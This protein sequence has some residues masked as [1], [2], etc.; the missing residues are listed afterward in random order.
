[1]KIFKLFFAVAAF[2]VS[3]G[4]QATDTRYDFS[5]TTSNGIAS[6]GYFILGESWEPTTSYQSVDIGDFYGTLSVGSVPLISSGTFSDLKVRNIPVI[7]P[8]GSFGIQF[9]VSG[10]TYTALD[11]KDTTD[12]KFPYS[13]TYATTSDGGKTYQTTESQIVARTFSAT[14]QVPEIDGSKLPQ[15]ALLILA[16]VFMVRRLKASRPR[17]NGQFA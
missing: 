5:F 9:T 4:A 7:N 17:F 3:L 1:M 15:A 12:F 16:L 2:V 6:S 8:S 13:L 14:T 11:N 10:T